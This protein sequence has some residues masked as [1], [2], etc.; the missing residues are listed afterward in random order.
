MRI[1]KTLLNEHCP[2]CGYI[3]VRIESTFDP[4]PGEVGSLEEQE[5]DGCSKCGWQRCVTFNHDYDPHNR[6]RHENPRVFNQA[7]FVIE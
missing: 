7:D 1:S 4:F 5:T 3:I 6:K 2:I